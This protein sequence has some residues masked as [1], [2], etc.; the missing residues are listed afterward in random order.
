MYIHIYG[1][2]LYIWTKQQKLWYI[3]I[4]TYFS[5][6]EGVGEGP[7][8]GQFDAEATDDALLTTLNID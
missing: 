6:Q 3:S 2:I 8:R 4:L 1:C 5:H 7:D